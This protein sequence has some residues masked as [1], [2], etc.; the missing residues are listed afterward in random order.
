M[1]KIMPI[2]NF[3]NTPSGATEC[4]LSVQGVADTHSVAALGVLTKLITGVLSAQLCMHWVALSTLGNKKFRQRNLGF[5]V[6]DEDLKISPSRLKLEKKISHKN[7]S[8]SLQS[9]VKKSLP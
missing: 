7:F 3:V 5:E 6:L 1:F 9:D 2:I 4:A 8:K